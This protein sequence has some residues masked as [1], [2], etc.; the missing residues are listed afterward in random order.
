MKHY[1]F[2]HL[3]LSLCNIY[4]TLKRI[5]LSFR[6]KLIPTF[7]EFVKWL[8]QQDSDKDDP[9]WNQYYKHCALC[10][11]KYDFVLKLD[12]Y[13]SYDIDY[14]FARLNINENN[15]Y[16]PK[17]EQTKAGC[18]NFEET[19]NYFKNLSHETVVNLYEKY[20]ID[21]DMFNYEFDKYF[22]CTEGD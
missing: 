8:L 2:Y 10:T 7:K 20:R 6:L 21:F 5:F 14:I 17:L 18:T 16:L 4:C 22:E 15:A 11:I 1:L 13:T 3:I 9:H 19:C 12:N